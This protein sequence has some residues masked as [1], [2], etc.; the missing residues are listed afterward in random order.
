MRFSSD[1][2][3]CGGRFGKSSN[4]IWTLSDSRRAIQHLSNW[5]KLGEV[6]ILEKLERLSSSREVHLQWVPS[7]VNEIDDSL[8]KEVTDQ[9]TTN[10]SHLFRTPLCLHE[11][12]EINCSS[13]SSLI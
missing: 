13:C 1:F 7:T 9:P 4:S 3:S 2:V 12:K 11:Q 8:A 6:A 5:H 10:H